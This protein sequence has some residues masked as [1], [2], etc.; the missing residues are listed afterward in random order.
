MI[1]LTRHLLPAFLLLSCALSVWADGVP[2]VLV[3]AS[4]HS[5]LAWTDEQVAGLRSGLKSARPAPDLFVEYLDTKRMR[6]SPRHYAQ[7]HDVLAH[8]YG[9]KYFDAIVAQ[10]DDALDFV[11]E[12]RRAGGLFA[13][14][15]VV[16]SGVTGQRQSAVE[17]LPAITGV[18]DDADIAANVT[19]LRKMRPSLSRV[20]FVHDHSR[21]GVAQ[22]ALARTLQSQFPGLPSNSSLISA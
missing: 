9:W 14:L 7:M 1:W 20:V 21:T 2:R 10:D 13:G 3:L 6:P 15:P 18:F 19:L 8:K 17:M 11:L 5:G 12:E 16:F 4:Y 22:A